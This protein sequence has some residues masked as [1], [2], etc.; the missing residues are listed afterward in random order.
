MAC[1]AL[2]SAQAALACLWL[3]ATAAAADSLPQVDWRGLYIGASLGGALSLTNIDDPF[4]PSIFGDTVRA[5]G[6]IAGGQA[7]YN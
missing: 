3:S 4:R 2:G 5:P 1:R 6:P 7:G